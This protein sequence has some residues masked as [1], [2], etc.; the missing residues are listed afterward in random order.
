MKKPYLVLKHFSRN[1]SIVLVG[2][3]PSV[4]KYKHGKKI[5]DFDIVVRFNSFKRIKEHT[6]MKTTFHVQSEDS[7]FVND[8]AQDAIPITIP[9]QVR[10]KFLNMLDNDLHLQLCIKH[11][12]KK[13]NDHYPST[14]LIFIMFLLSL[15]KRPLY[16]T[17]FDGNLNK[18]TTFDNL[19][20]YK[21]DS[22]IINALHK[23]GNHASERE[24][25]D[26]LVAKKY[27][28]YVQ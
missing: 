8:F 7:S 14:G 4:K 21:S 9:S 18:I 2:N 22:I 11:L 3:G 1:R 5:D 27:I 26:L 28:K 12:K 20:Y 23:N 15:L 24:I 16:I 10:T 6:G 13:L 25:F 19:H 17:G